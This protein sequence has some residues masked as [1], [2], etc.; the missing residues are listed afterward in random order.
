MSLRILRQLERRLVRGVLRGGRQKR[1]PAVLHV[2]PTNVCNLAC[3]VCPHGAARRGIIPPIRRKKGFMSPETF[4]AV[5]EGCGEAIG[6]MDLYL[7]GEPFLHEGLAAM[8]AAARERGIAVNLFSNGLAE[9]MDRKVEAVLEA[10]PV[11]ICLS[12]DLISREGYRRYKGEDLY[13]RACE[14]F[15]RIA[16]CFRRT[17]TKTKLIL[18]SIYSDETEAQVRRFL[19][20][21]FSCEALHGIQITHPFPW[22]GR[23]DAEVLSARLARR[24]ANVCPQVW[25]A[26]NVLWDGTVVPCSYDYE[27]LCPVGNVRETPVREMVNAPAMRRF[28]RRHLFGRRRSI[29]MCRDCFLPK[30][31]THVIAIRRKQFLRMNPE[32]Q[33]EL[34]RAVRGLVFDPAADFTRAQ[35]QTPKEAMPR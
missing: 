25:N 2:E 5:L 1:P 7:H 21:R 23:R 14:N 31:S 18:R 12:M 9:D 6:S 28:R 4:R 35:N 19:E 13:E 26:I 24:H 30:F 11:S 29:G 10:Q 20:E 32:E 16:E 15:S 8:A 22:P 3:T 33:T 27:G 34:C 17:K